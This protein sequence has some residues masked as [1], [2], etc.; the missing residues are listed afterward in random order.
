MGPTRSEDKILEITVK[1]G[2][3]AGTKVTFNDEGDRKPGHIPADIQFVIKEKPH[4]R[5]K[6][7][8]NDL[9]YTQKSV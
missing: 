4:P 3:K 9:I 2:W 7:D 1:P 6:R 8:G 5:F